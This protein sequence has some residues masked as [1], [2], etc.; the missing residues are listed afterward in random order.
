[1]TDTVVSPLTEINLDNDKIEY[2]LRYYHTDDK[3][4]QVYE[5]T[6]T[7]QQL[8]RFFKNKP[9]A[10]VIERVEVQ[11]TNLSQLAGLLANRFMF[12]KEEVMQVIT[13]FLESNHLTLEAK[14]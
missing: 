3:T 1:M 5:V 7:V 13:Y 11:L 12:V 8:L 14:T 6:G 9:T 10:S 2:L 4:K